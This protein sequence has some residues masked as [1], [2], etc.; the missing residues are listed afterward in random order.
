MSQTYKHAFLFSTVLLN[1]FFKVKA[2]EPVKTKLFII[3]DL[4]RTTNK[5]NTVAFQ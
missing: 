4:L 5:Q 2:A 3:G 1:I